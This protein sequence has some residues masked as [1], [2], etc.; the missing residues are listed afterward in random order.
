MYERSA[1]TPVLILVTVL[2]AACGESPV[3]NDALDETLLVPSFAALPPGWIQWN[4]TRTD[5]C[6][7]EDVYF[8]TRRIDRFESRVTRAG[9]IRLRVHRTWIGKGVGLDTGTEYEFNWP[10]QW[11]EDV[12]GPFPQTF[13]F[14]DGNSLISH[15]SADNRIFRSTRTLTVNANGEVTA[16][17]SHVTLE[18]VG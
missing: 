8:E 15:G 2:A 17:H 1:L 14:T 13:S 5:P 18:C 10:R 7:G 6:N 9:G 4:M 12:S 11:E 3:A 16:D